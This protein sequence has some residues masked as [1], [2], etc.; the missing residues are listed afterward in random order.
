MKR[1]LL[2]NL[3]SLLLIC[4]ND[5]WA[6]ACATSLGNAFTPAQQIALCGHFSTLGVGY[7]NYEAVAGAGT[8][9]GDAADLSGTK[10]VHQLTGANGTVGWQLPT[11]TA[12]N[13]NQVHVLLNTTAGVAKLWPESGGT[14]NGGSA[15]AAFSA[16]TG[17][18]PIICVATA[19]ATWI[20]S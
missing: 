10:F 7:S 9:I 11:V 20:C 15:S 18:K 19:A 2:L 1:I 13:V 4:R 8:V 12:A 5:A 17:I 16:L 6:D 14:I 3:L